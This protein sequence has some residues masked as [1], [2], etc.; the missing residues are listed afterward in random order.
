MNDEDNFLELYSKIEE[1]ASIIE[2]RPELKKQFEK[3]IEEYKKLLKKKYEASIVDEA[4]DGS[5][6][7]YNGCHGDLRVDCYP[8]EDIPG[9]VK[10]FV[11]D[12]NKSVSFIIHKK[13]PVFTTVDTGI[14]TGTASLAFRV[15]QDEF[16][17]YLKVEYLPNE[18][19]NDIKVNIYVY[20]SSG[21]EI[22]ITDD[23]GVPNIGLKYNSKDFNMGYFPLLQ[24]SS[25][26]YYVP[27]TRFTEGGF[28]QGSYIL[29]KLIADFNYSIKDKNDNVFLSSLFSME[30]SLL[31]RCFTDLHQHYGE[32]EFNERDITITIFNSTCLFCSREVS[33]GII[34]RYP[35]W[36]KIM[37]EEIDMYNERNPLRMQKAK[38]LLSPRKT[39]KKAGSKKKKRK[40]KRKI[41]RTKRTKRT[42]RSSKK[43]KIF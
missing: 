23:E 33:K 27:K 31:E 8:Y 36:A 10:D 13:T 30:E 28:F 5:F 15:N 42:K 21:K 17:E 35:Q 2:S 25:D 40:K 11:L 16:R 29:P 22:L 39:I 37:S 6:F 19:G 41:K 4:D 26:F 20:N 3:D 24:G 18:D 34:Q 9:S 32:E 1:T 7:Y 38:R 14:F 12:K 43:K